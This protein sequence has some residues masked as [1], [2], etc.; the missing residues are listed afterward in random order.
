MYFVFLFGLVQAA[1]CAGTASVAA[2]SQSVS[3]SPSKPTNA[4]QVPPNFVAF[5][6]DGEFLN[7]YNNPFSENLV[8]SVQDRMG[9]KT[10]IRIGG[11][12]SYVNP[13]QHLNM[14]LTSIQ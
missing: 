3:F 4:V 5:G 6:W 13:F 2:S 12:S 11:T 10:I 1:A 7:D 9:A 14:L 8:K